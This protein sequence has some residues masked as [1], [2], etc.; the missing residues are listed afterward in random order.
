MPTAIPH[1]IVCTHGMEEGA[2]GDRE[3]YKGKGVIWMDVKLQ[4][5]EEATT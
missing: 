2:A 3:G 1:Q 4:L 5:G